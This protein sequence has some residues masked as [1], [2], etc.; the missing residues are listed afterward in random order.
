[1]SSSRLGSLIGRTDYVITPDTVTSQN[2]LVTIPGGINLSTSGQIGSNV[3]D[4]VSAVQV[5]IKP[6][7]ALTSGTD[8]SLFAL[9]DSS[10][11][12]KVE[13]RADGSWQFGREA[14]S[15][16]TAA[17]MSVSVTRSEYTGINFNLASTGSG[18]SVGTLSNANSGGLFQTSVGGTPAGSYYVGGYFSA[19]TN[20]A[21]TGNLTGMWGM[22]ARAYIGSLQGSGRTFTEM[23]GLRV[24]GMLGGK[25]LGTLTDWYGLYVENASVNAMGSGSTLTNG[26]GVYV[27]EQ[28]RGATV[29]NGIFL[30]NATAGYKAI[31]IRDQNAWIGSS[32]AA[33]ID[34]GATEFKI[35]SSKIGFYNT[36]PQSQSTG[37]S[38]SNVSSDKTYDANATTVDELADVLG[39]LIADLKTYGLLG[40]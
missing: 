30:A 9:Q 29:N 5:L 13:C 8:R 20:A 33:T 15:A 21:L 16:A 24:M 11:N 7:V 23:G 1:M 34:I 26:R 36:A 25:N 4:A 35:Q 32:A 39:T 19:T 2:D 22:G 18:G 14:G 3:A 12:A 40:A 17:Y 27:E 31:A 6:T 10:A 38:V 37:W 28:T